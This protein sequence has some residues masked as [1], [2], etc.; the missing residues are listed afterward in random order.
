VKPRS[1]YQRSIVSSTTSVKLLAGALMA[2][3][4]PVAS[5]QAL[6]KTVIVGTPASA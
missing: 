3:L 1:I 5:A 4:V 6:T 2:L